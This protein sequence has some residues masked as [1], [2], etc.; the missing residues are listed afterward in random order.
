MKQQQFNSVAIM[1]VHM[2]E[3]K[4]LLIASLLRILSVESV[5]KNSFYL[6]LS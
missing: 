5:Q 2:K 4:A 6:V 3:T 1:D